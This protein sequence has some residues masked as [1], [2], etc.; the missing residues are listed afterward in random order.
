MPSCATRQNEV[1]LPPGSSVFI[2]LIFMAVDK[3]W[4]EE[5]SAAQKVPDMVIMCH[6]HCDVTRRTMIAMDTMRSNDGV[7]DSKPSIAKSIGGPNC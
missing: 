3:G 5:I 2:D 7:Y 4:H 6:T 1:V